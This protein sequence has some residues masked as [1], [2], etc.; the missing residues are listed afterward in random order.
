MSDPEN[1]PIPKRDGGRRLRAGLRR[2]GVVP[3]PADLRRRLRAADVH[4]TEGNVIDLFPDV[5]AGLSAMLDAIAGATKR[6]HLETYILRA[7][8]TGDRKSVV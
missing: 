5:V 4:F 2:H 1:R 7:D 8:E 3:R 6:I